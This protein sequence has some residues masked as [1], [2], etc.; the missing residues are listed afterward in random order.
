MPLSMSESLLL[1]AESQALGNPTCSLNAPAKQC[2]AGSPTWHGEE[3]LD[4]SKQ[5]VLR[6]QLFKEGVH[7]QKDACSQLQE[8]LSTHKRNRADRSHTAASESG[9]EGP[10][11]AMG[12]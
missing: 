7:L 3:V 5:G 4:W 8:E 12:L 10:L 6:S 11:K 9:W 1:Y 2:Q